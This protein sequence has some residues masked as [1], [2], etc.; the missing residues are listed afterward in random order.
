MDSFV[1]GLLEDPAIPEQVGRKSQGL[2]RLQY[3]R[4]ASSFVRVLQASRRKEVYT[5]TI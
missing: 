4:T 5:N 3:G 1:L 2:F